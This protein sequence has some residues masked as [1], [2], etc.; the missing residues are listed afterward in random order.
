M[1][2]HRPRRHEVLIATLGTRPEVITL[3][4]D[5]LLD[6]CPIYRVVVIH[7]AQSFM[8]IGRALNRLHH[9][10]PNGIRYAH[11][12]VP[13]TYDTVELR[14]DGQPIEDIATK[15]HAGAAFTA[16]YQQVQHHKQ[17]GH[18]IH[19]SIAGGRKSMSVYGMA[20]AE[21]LFD[22]EDRLWHILSHPVFEET[23]AMHTDKPDDVKLVRIPVLSNSYVN[24]VLSELLI[25][26]DPM[27]AVERQQHMLT[28]EQRRRRR[29]FLKEVLTPSEY[30][31]VETLMW[32]IIVENRAPT[33]DELGRKLIVVER[34]VERRF[35]SI[36]AKLQ[37]FLDLT[38]RGNQPVLIAF[39]SPYFS[40]KFEAT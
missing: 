34:T 40:E 4:L 5:L 27:R 20:A 13:C 15:D 30:L 2:S 10:F 25:T 8:P 7:T 18:R 31:L 11:K 9:E 17:A 22:T 3:A 35:N 33:Y 24:P 39:I 6:K 36:Y 38:E 12:N 1:V 14:V 19:L 37:D 28:L 21:L 32:E 16:I 29:Q 23:D 26:D